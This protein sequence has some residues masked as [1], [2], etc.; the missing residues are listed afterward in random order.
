M[1]HPYRDFCFCL[2][3]DSHR[4]FVRLYGEGVPT[5]KIIQGEVIKD[6]KE[7]EA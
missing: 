5:G 1:T 2:L 3:C 4:R 6:Q 7:L